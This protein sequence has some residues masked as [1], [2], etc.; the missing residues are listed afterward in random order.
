ML[1]R[2]SATARRPLL[3]RRTVRNQAGD[4]L[5]PGQG[6]VGAVAGGTIQA[7]A[8]GGLLEERRG[9]GRAARRD[10]DPIEGRL[11]RPAERPTAHADP[12]V[13]VAELLEEASRPL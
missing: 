11:V 8:E 6:G 10:Q 4:F 3:G 5:E 12:H 1:A 2:I 9:N 13:V 7:P